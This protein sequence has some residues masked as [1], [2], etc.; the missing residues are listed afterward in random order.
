MIGV[1]RRVAAIG[2]LMVLICLLTCWMPV[3]AASTLFAIIIGVG[4]LAIPVLA[5][6]NLVAVLLN[7]AAGLRGRESGD[8][9]DARPE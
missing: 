1:T 2:T 6:C 5:V 8:N 9:A 7:G 4:L 3:A